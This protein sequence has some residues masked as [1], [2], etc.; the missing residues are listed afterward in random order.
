MARIPSFEE[1]LLEVHQS[2]GLKTYINQKT[3][4]KEAYPSRWK[5]DFSDLGMSLGRYT[6]EANKML[7]A[8]FQALDMDAIACRDASLNVWEWRNFHKALELRTWT[9][10]ASLQ[11]VL[12]HLLAYCY[13]PALG[14]RLAFWSL[15][16]V[17]R[18]LPMDAGMPGGKFWFM[19]HWHKKSRLSQFVAVCWG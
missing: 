9:G 13:V 7:H 2:L 10:S 8:I 14:R 1:I 16:G 18:G 6:D 12:W 17:E 11:Q 15:D 4:E 5:S 19:P 3:G